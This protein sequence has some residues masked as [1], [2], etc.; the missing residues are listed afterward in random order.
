MAVR[1]QLQE[2]TRIELES[3]KHRHEMLPGAPGLEK[4][5]V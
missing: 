4:M 1:V 5:R 2:A 3:G